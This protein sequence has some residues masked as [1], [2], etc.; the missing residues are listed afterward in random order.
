MPYYVSK[1]AF[2]HHPFPWLDEK[3]DRLRPFAVSANP[4]PRFGTSVVDTRAII[5]FPQLFFHVRYSVVT[6]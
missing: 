6:E 2:T 4:G 1:E 3:D 5:N